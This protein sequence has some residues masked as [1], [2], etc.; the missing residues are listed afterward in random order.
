MLPYF[1]TENIEKVTTFI[2]EMCISIFI[3]EIEKIL[4]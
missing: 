2:Y 1:Q 3:Y 4:K